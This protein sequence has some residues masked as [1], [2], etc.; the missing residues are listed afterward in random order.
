MVITLGDKMTENEVLPWSNGEITVNDEADVFVNNKKANIVVKDNKKFVWL[1]WING[2]DFYELGLVIG[3]AFQK[4]TLPKQFI[5]EVE[6]TYLDN[7]PLNCFPANLSHVYKKDPVETERKGFYYVPGFANYGINK[8][9]VL[10]NLETGKVKTWTVSP[11]DTER[12][13]AAGYKYAV[14]YYNTVSKNVYQHRLLAIMFL[15]PIHGIFGLTVNHKDGNK[16]NNALDNLEWVSYS[17]N[18]KHAWDNKL[19]FSTNRVL[20]K[21]LLTEEIKS[22]RS[23]RA[24][25]DLLGDEN[26]FYVKSRLEDKSNKVYPDFLAFKYNDESSWPEFGVRIPSDLVEP[27]L[28]IV[29]R[30]VFTNDIGVF[31]TAEEAAMMVGVKKALILDHCRCNKVLPANGYNFRFRINA[32]DWPVFEARQLEIFK[33]SPISPSNG[34]LVLDH[35]TKE[36][37]FF[38][39]AEE[40]AE[41]FGVSKRFI[42]TYAALK[43]SFH[44]RYSIRFYN[45]R[46]S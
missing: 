3:C 44:K 34:F 8:A 23:I 22:F 4:V 36:E 2:L 9:G 46:G 26:G 10:I 20:M 17:E 32:F 28:F 38:R 37:M 25:A 43:K 19:R 13:R 31:E 40:C 27:D 16:N 42:Q 45:V 6:I 1:D 33:V 35:E 29:A 11:G 30:N 14:L 5:G 41:R 24:C 12:N 18:L 39:T 7:D 15:K 21:N